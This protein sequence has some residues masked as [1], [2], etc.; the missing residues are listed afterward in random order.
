MTRL[1]LAMAAV[2]QSAARHSEFAGYRAGQQFGLV[3]AAI[4]GTRPTGRCP[5]NNIDFADAEATHHQLGK[6]VRDASPISVLEAMQ[7]LAGHTIEGQRCQNAV[8]A[9]LR[10]GTGK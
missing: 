4:S 1:L 7:H 9:D 5:G 2:Q 3:V 8:V 10:G 6:L